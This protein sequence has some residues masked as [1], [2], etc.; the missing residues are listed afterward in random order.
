MPRST[1]RFARQHRFGPPPPFRE[2][3]TCLGID[4][5]ASGCAPMT[6][7][8]HTPPLTPR[9]AAGSCFRYGYS[10][11]RLAS[12]SNRTPWPVLQHGRWNDGPSQLRDFFPFSLHQVIAIRFQALFTPLPRYFSTFPHGTSSLSDSGCI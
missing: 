9:G 2:A 3:S 5:P 4:Q 11:T 10:L 6:P 8:E 7:G 12:P 1:E